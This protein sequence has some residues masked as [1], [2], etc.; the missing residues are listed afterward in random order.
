MRGFQRWM[1]HHPKKRT[2][3]YFS[4][5]GKELKHEQ[6]KRIVDYAVEKGYLTDADIPGEEIE[7][8]LQ[9]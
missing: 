8:L 6:I 7:K 3:G 1:K 5:M 2:D 4:F 9:L